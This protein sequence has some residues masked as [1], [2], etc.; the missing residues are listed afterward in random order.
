MAKAVP[1]R[2]FI[3]YSHDS[4]AHRDRVLDFADRLRGD[5]VDADID[6]YIQFPP[7]GWPAW[8]AMQIREADFVLV[9]CTETYR[10][11]VDGDEEPGAGHGVLWEGRLIKQ[12]LYDLG[13]VSGKF[14]PVL[15]ADGSHDHVPASVR[16]GSI[17]RIETGEGYEALLRLLTDQPL[18]PMPPLGRLR[19]LAP[20]Q[21]Q[22]EWAGPRLNLDQQ[23]IPLGSAP[24]EEH[25]APSNSE[26]S[27]DQQTTLL[28]NYMTYS[29]AEI[30]Y[31]EL[32]WKSG[33]S[34][35][36]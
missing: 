8:C 30:I 36:V 23:T 4:D 33:H 17:Y 29:L 27:I 18:T 21:R 28:Q 15:F 5:G 20:R 3:S 34:H 7:E 13:S 35:E 11:R 26:A 9:V 14:V 6:Q 10:R 16:G 2:V 19:E 12:H 1:P 25:R 24:R 31:R 32:L 22:R